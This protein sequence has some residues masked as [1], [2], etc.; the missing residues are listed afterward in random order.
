MTT[1]LIPARISRSWTRRNFNRSSSR[2]PPTWRASGRY[3]SSCHSPSSRYTT[4]AT[5]W[6]S[7]NIAVPSRDFRCAAHGRRTFFLLFESG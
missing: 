2:S 5:S 4:S 3:A 7:E 1:T 6:R